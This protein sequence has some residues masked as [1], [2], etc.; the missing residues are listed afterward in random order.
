MSNKW[1]DLL[2]ATKLNDPCEG[3]HYIY[4]S[5]FPAGIGIID[6]KN[7]KEYC[8]KRSLSFYEIYTKIKS[9]IY[10]SSFSYKY[11]SMPMW[12]H[13]ASNHEG[14]CIEYEVINS[15]KLYEIHYFAG[16]ID[17]GLEMERLFD[18]YARMEISEKEYYDILDKISI[19]LY[20]IKSKEWQYEQEARIILSSKGSQSF[21]FNISCKELGLKIKNVCF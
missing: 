13:Y 12:A 21:G 2:N 8:K 4:S 1:E 3:Q 16:K 17:I 14:I 9:L 11:N 19:W 7:A 10:T 20:T 18:E 5:L 6:E 15:S